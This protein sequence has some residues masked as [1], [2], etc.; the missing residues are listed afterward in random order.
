MSLSPL[1]LAPIASLTN[2]FTQM[3]ST[4]N[5]SMSIPYTISNGISSVITL[6]LGSFWCSSLGLASSLVLSN[7]S[8]TSGSLYFI[9][10]S[11]LNQ[12]IFWVSFNVSNYL[13][14]R[15]PLISFNLSSTNNLLIG[16]GTTSIQLIQ[17]QHTFTILNTITTF[18][19]QT[20]FRIT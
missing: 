9:S 2:Y 3:N 20:I 18:A 1:V 7:V 8:C 19:A 15:Q 16:S 4:Y 17:N 5:I 11:I 14:A 6:D 12:G 10:S 13:S